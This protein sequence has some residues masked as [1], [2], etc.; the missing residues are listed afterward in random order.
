MFEAKAI[1]CQ[2]VLGD[3]LESV[4]TREQIYKATFRDGLED[5]LQEVQSGQTKKVI[6]FDDFSD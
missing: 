2:K 3:F 1:H 6:S 4:L 5:A